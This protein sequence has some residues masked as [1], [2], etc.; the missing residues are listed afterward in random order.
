MSLTLLLVLGS[1]FVL[2]APGAEAKQKFMSGF[3]QAYPAAA[4][5]PLDSCLLCHTNPVNPG[6]NNL[7][8]YGKD[9]EDGDFGDKNYLEPALVNRDSDRDGIPNGQEIQQ[10]SLPGDPSS[11]APP[12]TTTTVPGAPPNGQALYAARCSVCHGPGGGDLSG[13]TR[14][15][16]TFITITLNGQGGMPPQS[17][18][19][20]G[21]AGAIWDY[22]TGTV[23]AT[24]TTT[25]PGAT[26]APAGGATV[27]AQQCAACHGANGGDVV[28]TSRSNAQLVSIVT[29]GVPGMR[30]FPEL[31]TAQISNVA[32]Y[33][34][35]LSVPPTTQPGA[36]TTTTSPRSGA[37]VYA[38][39]CAL[40][41][42]ADGGNLRG[43]TLNLS[44]IVSATSNGVGTMSGYAS[45]LSAAEINNVAVYVASVGASAGVTTTTAPPG[46]PLSGSMLYQ[47]NCSACH[48]LHGEGGPGG[49]VAGTALSRS[50]TIGVI[51]GG[52]SGM[53]G[54]ASQLSA[55]QIAAVA[56]HVLGI[57]GRDIAAADSAPDRSVIPTELVE[58]HALFGRFCAACHGV[59]GEGGL[60][61][62]V[63]G[64]NIAADEL[65]EIIRAGVGSMPGFADRMSA[66]EVEALVAY[67]QALASGREF[68][69]ADT[70]TT[71]GQAPTPRD[72]GPQALG[73]SEPDPSTSHSA[74][75][76]VVIS[77]VAGLIA[78]GAAVL[79]ARLGRD[80]IN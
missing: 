25:R 22:V 79:W 6:E 40:C 58:G 9:W 49:A 41:H 71:S 12:T 18:L 2:L 37:A 27:W 3:A 10:L 14:A 47:Q 63:A 23:P 78:T 21:E 51:T 46:S 72:S 75:P 53:P 19:S 74:W 11:I 15:R 80:L 69:V 50:Q 35:S 20:T 1:A 24:T 77:L 57:A 36:T 16:S 32:G 33:L 70:T 28:P 76:V 48:G 60:G 55:G 5:T 7:N 17:G 45:R 31:G 30:G 43:H 68:E 59:N 61:G 29:N 38:A 64:I 26:T 4:G 42:G 8:N 34:L 52:A 65:G 56:D 66:A 39:S 62:P 67:S 73:V 44:R 54:Y 13:T